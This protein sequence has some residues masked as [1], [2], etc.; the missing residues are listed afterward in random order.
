MNFDYAII[1]GLLAV[2]AAMKHSG[3]GWHFGAAL[4]I[5]RSVDG[6][7]GAKREAIGSNF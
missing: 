7:S 5:A 3:P 2:Y 6:A 1:V 4:Q